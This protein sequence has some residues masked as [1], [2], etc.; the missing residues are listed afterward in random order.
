MI[1]ISFIIMLI[2]YDQW[3]W[4]E[5]ILHAPIIWSSHAWSNVVPRPT[6]DASVS[7]YNGFL[8]L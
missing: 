2:L 1:P 6:P 5:A 3:P 4:I 8:T 7:K